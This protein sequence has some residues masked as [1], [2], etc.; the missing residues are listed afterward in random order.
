MKHLASAFF[1]IAVILFLVAGP[2]FSHHA[3]EA[4]FDPGQSLTLTGL[5]TK[6]DW[7]NPHVHIFM[8]VQDGLVTTAW[9]V[10]L[11]SQLDLQRSGWDRDALEVG[12]TIS[13]DGIVA[14]DG[15]SQIWGNS[16]VLASTGARLFTLT[17][18]QPEVSDAAPRETP[19]WPNGVPRLGPA[20]GERGYWGNPSLTALVETGAEGG[21]VAMDVNGLLA[22]IDDVDRVA[23]FRQWARDLY[24]L[25]QRDAL[26]DDPLFLYCKPP[27]GPRQFQL[28]HGVQFIQ[29][30]SRE[31][32]WVMIGG[33]NH[34]W[35]FIYLD[36]RDQNDPAQI[37]FG[38][39]KYY[40]RAV[41]EWEG[42]TLVVDTID[43]NEDFWFS[44][45]GVPHTEQ[46]HLVERISR[47]DYNT[48][49]Y[50]VTIDDPW[51]YTRSWTSSWTLE[52]IPDQ[53]LARYFCQDNRP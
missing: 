30:Q 35:R 17:D 12:D 9:A 20:P 18:S 44:N 14:R 25:R 8:D 43:F 33:G 28:P 1:V 26:K 24:E 22:D 53:E 11:E 49:R 23:P 15:S 5:I 19:R 48:L 47:P 3:I 42:D 29:E 27:G 50:E 21:E 10:E 13:V 2:L 39:P 45:G 51:A 4:K 52:W 16:L 7:L 46:L 37:D 32:I 31:R 40:G 36:G 6:V 38:H 41:A 34:N